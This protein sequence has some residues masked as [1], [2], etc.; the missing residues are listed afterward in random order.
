MERVAEGKRGAAE[1]GEGEEAADERGCT[2]KAARARARR[3]SAP[4]RGRCNSVVGRK[5]G[6]DIALAAGRFLAPDGPLH[7]GV[8]LL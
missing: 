7:L 6:Q 8:G 1:R 3:G 2:E 5:A 4:A